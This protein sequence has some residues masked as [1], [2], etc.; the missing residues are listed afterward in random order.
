MLSTWFGVKC[1]CKYTRI[2]RVLP[3][4]NI[5]NAEWIHAELC[6]RAVLDGC[7]NGCGGA[8]ERTD[9]RHNSV[10]LLT[11]MAVYHI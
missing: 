3:A 4:E 11:Y 5:A 1:A 8:L 9:Y 2:L 7:M 10:D 6:E